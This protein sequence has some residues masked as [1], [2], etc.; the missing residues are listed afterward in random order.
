MSFYNKS[1]I[2]PIL[3][4]PTEIPESPGLLDVAFRDVDNFINRFYGELY[5]PRNNFSFRQKSLILSY[6]F[7]KNSFEMAHPKQKYYKITKLTDSLQ[8]DEINEYLGHLTQLDSYNRVFL[9]S[10]MGE[11]LNTLA[12]TGYILGTLLSGCLWVTIFRN[13]GYVKKIPIILT[14]IHLSG[15]FNKFYKIHINYRSICLLQ[16]FRQD[17]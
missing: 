4:L 5:K 1:Q 16:K 6:L 3:P 7:H 14:L 17:F 10:A 2:S 11:S 9:V 13:V 8:K 12:K 15:L